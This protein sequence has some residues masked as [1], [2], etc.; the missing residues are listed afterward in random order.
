MVF[1]KVFPSSSFAV[2]VA[3]ETPAAAGVPLTT[4]ALPFTSEVRPAGSPVIEYVE[5]PS[6]E[7]K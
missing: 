2:I 3:T 4:S 6:S 5:Y 1:V 7:S